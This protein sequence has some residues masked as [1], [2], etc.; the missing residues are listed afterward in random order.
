M[1]RFLRLWS[2]AGLVLVNVE[3]RAARTFLTSGAVFGDLSL[4][5]VLLIPP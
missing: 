3:A 2:R 5:R 4:R 1:V